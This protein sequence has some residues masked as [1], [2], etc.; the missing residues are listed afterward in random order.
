MKDLNLPSQLV[1]KEI[2]DLDFTGNV[3]IIGEVP[4]EVVSEISPKAN[5][6]KILT[7]DFPHFQ[8]LSSLEIES[9][10]FDLGKS[11]VE[12]GLK[13]DRVLVYLPKGDDLIDYVFALASSVVKMSSLVFVVGEKSAGIK[14]QG[15]VLDGFGFEVTDYRFGRHSG[16]FVNRVLKLGDGVDIEKY[17]SSFEVEPG[18]KAWAFPGVFASGRVDTGTKLLLGA[19][20]LRGVKNI[21]D[22]GCGSGIVGVW[23]LSKN[24]DVSVECTDSS[25]FAVEATTRTLKEFDL[26][27]KRW[28]VFPSDV[29][30]EVEVKFDLIIVNPPFHH[31]IKT[32][33][34]AAVRMLTTAGK[35]LEK[36]GKIVVVANNFLDY[37]RRLE[38]VFGNCVVIAKDKSYNVYLSEGKNLESRNSFTR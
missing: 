4:L 34:S 11:V 7:F 8:S 19:L 27:G 30:S 29:Y 5:S 24:S 25:V 23:A 32:E 13:F 35:H 9:V 6:V 16:L 22:L 21:L 37:R 31:G 14:S 28:K 18:L 38:A 17:F 36:N 2:D 10:V 3:L 12:E 33:Y 26:S 20:D 1:L 15:K